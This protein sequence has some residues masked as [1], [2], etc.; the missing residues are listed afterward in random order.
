[1]KPD[2]KINT[3]FKA[4]YFIPLTYTT[5]YFNAFFDTIKRF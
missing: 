2:N 3:I 5:I 1:V 4:F